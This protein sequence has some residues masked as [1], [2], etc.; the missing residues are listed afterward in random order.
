MRTRM[1][2]A[3]SRIKFSCSVFLTSMLLVGATATAAAVE[4]EVA[5]S[6]V[7]AGTSP[8]GAVDGDRFAFPSR[9]RSVRFSR[10]TATGP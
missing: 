4:G 2:T 6:S 3:F 5:A 7:A 10:S 1:K 8:G 9:G